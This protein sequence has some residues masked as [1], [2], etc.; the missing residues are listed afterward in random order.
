MS[1]VGTP[2]SEATTRSRSSKA[3]CVT[4]ARASC[5]A[6]AG[7][8]TSRRCVAPASARRRAIRPP[9]RPV[10]PVTATTARGSVIGSLGSAGSTAAA[11]TAP[12]EQPPQCRADARP[13]RIARLRRPGVDHL[14][15]DHDAR[16][17][18]VTTTIFPP[19]VPASMMQCASW[20]SSRSSTF[21]IGTV[22]VPA[23]TSSR[24][25]WRTS[26]G[27]LVASPV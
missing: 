21:P 27:R 9:R 11:Q 4:D 19:A 15:V 22:A 24:K 7:S 14:R 13:T 26:A 8:R 6:R 3:A 16:P 10:A 18:A 17:E 1:T 20:I 12:H 23:A 2:L 5:G 25:R